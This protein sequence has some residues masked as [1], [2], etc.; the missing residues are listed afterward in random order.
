MG[1]SV[2][3][4]GATQPEDVGVSDPSPAPVNRRPPF[5]DLEFDRREAGMPASRFAQLVGIPA[6]TDRRWLVKAGQ[7]LPPTEP[8]PTPA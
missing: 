1:T 3:T 6:R 4:L 8:W 2:A 5:A 7:T